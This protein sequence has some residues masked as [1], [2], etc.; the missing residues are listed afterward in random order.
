MHNKSTQA[1]IVGLDSCL[2]SFGE[3]PKFGKGAMVEMDGSGLDTVGPVSTP[4]V[5]IP[6]A[7]WFKR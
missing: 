2:G 7:D 6:V 1:S 4:A 5:A 3:A